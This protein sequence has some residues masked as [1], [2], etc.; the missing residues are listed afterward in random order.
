M[1]QRQYIITFSLIVAFT[2]LSPVMA[3]DAGIA[4]GHRH[5]H[6]TNVPVENTR[7]ITLSHEQM[8]QVKG[9]R[10]LYQVCS[11]DVC[12]GYDTERGYYY[13]YTNQFGPGSSFT[14]ANGT[15]VSTY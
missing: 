9:G 15:T 6:S 1:K 5:I 13:G 8:D 4:P 14:D 2:G 12:S 11:N 3:A 10:I 7:P